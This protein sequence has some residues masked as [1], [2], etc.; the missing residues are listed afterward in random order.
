MFHIRTTKTASYA[1]AVQILR[2]ENRKKI[3]VLHVGSAHNKEELSKLKHIATLWIENTTK[4]QTL[5]PLNSRG[6]QII[7]LNKCQ[8]T[9]FYYALIYEAIAKLFIHFKFHLLHNKLLTDLVTAR[10]VEPCSK[11][12]SLK[13]L[14]QFFGICHK[15]RD[16]YRQLPKFPVLKNNVESKIL[17]VA[18][19]ELNFNFSLVLYDVTTLYFETFRE[20]GF[21]KHGFSKDNKANQPQILIGLLVNTNGFPVAYHVFPGNKFEGHTLI[22]VISS[23]KRKHK[24][25]SFTVVADAAMIS[26]D[27]I[28]ALE[29]NTLNY[30]VGARMG[31]LALPQIKVISSSLS[32][33]NSSS[34][35]VNTNHGTLICDFSRKRYRK[36]KL[37]ME[38]QI[39]K[40]KRLLKEQSTVKRTKFLKRSDKTAKTDYAINTELI[41]K[42]RL[43]LGIKGY[44]TNLGEEYD[45]SA[46]INHYHSL[47]HVEQAFRIAKSDLQMR[48]IYHFKQYAIEAHILIC[49]MALAVSKYMEIKTG[50]SIKAIVE[51]LKNVTDAKL[52]NTVTHEEIILR[53]II[54]DDVQQ[55][56]NQFGLW[57]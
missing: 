39:N 36:D 38:R 29:D 44:Y 52:I 42:T 32:Q 34:I 27:N 15:Y 24:I 35:R 9:G 57:Y 40:A 55:L 28:K 43:L 1:T 50:K 56:L 14:N 22:P 3:I 11:R 5:F 47:W 46:I 45:N 13:F 25:G 26:F 7:P 23:F 16:L 53:S 2:Y 19:K 10:I 17:A 37:E 30:I 18:K 54:T 31:N 4:Q 51:L 33:V 12:H 49:F 20:D 6:S 41:E 48:P 8:Y 21:R